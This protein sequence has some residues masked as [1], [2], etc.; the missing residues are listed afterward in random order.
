MPIK[1]DNLYRHF[2]KSIPHPSNYPRITNVSATS[3]G[4]ITW[5]TDVASTSQVFYGTIPY[6]GIE[7][8]RDS[9]YVTSHSVQLEDL[10]D[11]TTYFFRVLSFNIDALSISDLYTFNTSPGTTNVPAFILRSPDTT[12]WGVSITTDGNLDTNVTPVG[13]TGAYAPVSGTIVMLAT[14][15]SPWTISIDD[16]G[17]L[18]TTAGGSSPIALLTVLDS[19]LVLWTVTISPQGNLITT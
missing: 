13:P 1:L 6:L 2:Y 7:T 9:T 12:R 8:D 5:T 11:D 14:D 15:L 3:D 19:A 16:T 18:I 17:H 10:V 4:L